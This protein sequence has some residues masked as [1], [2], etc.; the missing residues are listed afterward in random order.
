MQYQQF[1]S[2]LHQPINLVG[3]KVKAS[4]PSM[5]AKAGDTAYQFASKAVHTYGQ[6]A[7]E[8]LH[9]YTSFVKPAFAEISVDGFCNPQVSRYL[10]E[11]DFRNLIRG[12]DG[13]IT[14]GG[15]VISRSPDVLREAGD[16]AACLNSLYGPG[17]A[18]KVQ[19]FTPQAMEYFMDNYAALKSTAPTLVSSMTVPEFGV[20]ALGAMAGIIGGA[21]VVQRYSPKIASGAKYVARHTKNLFRQIGRKIT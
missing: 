4:A 7:I 19:S 10:K 2:A 16:K 13:G 9:N 15:D 5:I 8:M 3:E 18:D 17:T 20:E 21:I 14:G 12:I 11:V 1:V 6:K